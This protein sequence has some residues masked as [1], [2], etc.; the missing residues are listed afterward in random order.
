MN[1]SELI[2]MLQRESPLF[3]RVK[4][5]I[6]AAH[7]GKATRTKLVAGQILLVPRQ[8][9]GHVYI[10]LSGRLRAQLNLDENMKPIALFGLG[11]CVGEM[12]MFEDNLVSAYVIAITDCELLSIAHADVWAILNESLQASHNMLNI[13]AERM[14]SSNRLLAKTM[15]N[16]PGYEALDYINTVTGIYNRRWLAE[17]TARL[18]H[19]HTINHQACAFILLRVNNFEQYGVKFGSLGSDQAQRTIAQAMLR[20]L[21]PNDVAVHLSENQFAVFLPQTKLENVSTVID[22]LQDEIGAANIATA[23]GDALPPLS[24]SFGAA[25]VNAHDALD[26]LIARALDT[27]RQTQAAVR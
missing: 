15:E 13:L 4:S 5:S 26:D 1:S 24:I 2:L 23:E 25:P 12:S 18:I 8:Q 19:R 11:E 20:C 6:L 10:I 7:L 21:R 16:T 9:N 27:M 3:S 14:R 22:R 17:N